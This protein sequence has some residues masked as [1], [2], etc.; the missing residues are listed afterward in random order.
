[1]LMNALLLPLT[2]IA[3]GGGVSTITPSATPTRATTLE[4]TSEGAF[5]HRRYGGTLVNVTTSEAFTNGGALWTHTDGGAAWIGSAVSIGNIGSQVFT[6]YDLN[7]EAAELFSVYDSDPPTPIWSDGGPLDTEFRMVDSATATDTHVAIS[8]IVLGGNSTTRQAVLRKYSSG[9]GTPDWTYTFTPV[10]N[11]GSKVGISRDGS[12]IVAAIM[13]SN[14]TSVEIAV[15]GPDSGTPTS[16]TVLPPGS[17]NSLRGWDLS[18][19]G[20]T[21]Y[22]SQGTDVNI[23]D[24][25]AQAVIFTT[26]AGA[27][28]DSHSI[29]GDG[30]VFAYG[31]FGFMRVF[32]YN[33]L[34]YV[35]T[36]TQTLGGSNYCARIDISDDSSTV[37]YGWYFYSPGLVVRIEA[38]D[39]VTGTVTMSELVTGTGAYQ[40]V[41]SD[42]SCSA[43]GSRFAVGLWGDAGNLAAELRLYSN[44]QSSPLQTLNLG[45]SIF[46]VDLS[47]DGQRVVGGGKAVHANQFGNGGHVEVLDEG[48]EDFIMRGAPR[49]GT[50]PDLEIYGPAGQPAILISSHLPQDPPIVFPQAGTLYVKRSQLTFT[51]IGPVPAGGMKIKSYP[52][53]SDNALVGTNQYLQVFFLN[54]RRLTKDY[55]KITFLP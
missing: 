9:S 23:Y 1:M 8:Q 55:M 54:P 12:T 28:F 30:S 19:D 50:A 5:E 29:S 48:D 45:G 2:L 25:A 21:L 35:N 4:V 22:Y 16:Y 6:E 20:T 37:A 26:N 36:H 52:I 15:F 31:G 43:D 33:G 47:A 51:A 7:N 13:N 44:T 41:V 49:I 34:T 53:A 14:T 46:D 3:T 24:V 27:S 11:A 10:I 17:N 38:L 39:L 42:I 18:A 40:N 32:T